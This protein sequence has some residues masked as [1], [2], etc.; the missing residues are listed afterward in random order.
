MRRTGSLL[1]KIKKKIRKSVDYQ[2][3]S[4]SVV[5]HRERCDRDITIATIFQLSHLVYHRERCDRDI[6][7]RDVTIKFAP[8]YH[9]ERCD[10]DITKYF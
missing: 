4:F 9:R 6:T 10:R 2:R 5:Y 7:S 3:F 1:Y 8:V